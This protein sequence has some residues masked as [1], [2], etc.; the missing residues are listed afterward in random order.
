MYAHVCATDYMWRSKDNLCE[1][2]FTIWVLGIE[3]R[4][5]GLEASTIAQRI[6]SLVPGPS[7]E[8]RL[9]L[10][11]KAGVSDS[12]TGGVNGAWF[13]NEVTASVEE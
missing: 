4:S 11:C 5:L 9:K 13:R 7:F 2:V 1:L 12:D 3:F 10:V 6:L 8:G